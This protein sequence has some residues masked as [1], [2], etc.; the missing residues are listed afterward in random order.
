MRLS[1]LPLVMALAA[2]L[3][4]ALLPPTGAP[5][6][7]AA[8][9]TDSA[10][11]N[12]GSAVPCLTQADKFAVS[13]FADTIYHPAPA[14]DPA[15]AEAS[16][17]AKAALSSVGTNNNGGAGARVASGI[18]SVYGL[19]YDDGAVSGRPRLFIAAF[20]KRLSGFGHGGP[21]GVYVYDL[22]QRSGSDAARFI[23]PDAGWDRA[24]GVA[25]PTDR[26]AIAHVGRSGLGDMEISPDG[27][28]LFVVNI[29]AR[30]IERY[31][32]SGETPVRGTPIS[33]EGALDAIWAPL[34]N[35][36]GA[37]EAA[38]RADT[39][40]FALEFSPLD[41]AANPRLVL[42]LTDTNRRA[43][44]DGGLNP[45]TAYP[46]F[47]LASYALTS[48]V[49]S[50][51]LSQ[52]LDHPTIRNRM[53]D[54]QID[55][56]WAS[57][58]EPDSAHPYGARG[59]AGWNPWHDNLAQMPQI[60]VTGLNQAIIYPQ[61]LLADIEF[62][63]DGRR[64]Y[65]GL[66][67]RTGD[68]VFAA[69]PPPGEFSAVAQGDTLVYN[70]Q[71]AAW[72][73][74]TTARTSD[75][76]N[77]D[78][79]EQFVRPALS[80]FFDDNRHRFAANVSPFH[81]E[82]HGGA[83]ATTLQG[84]GKTIAERIVT[85]SLLGARQSGLTFYSQDGGAWASAPNV[86]VTASR[87]A[88]GKS[89]VLGDLEPLCTYAFV[90][91]KVWNDLDGEGDQDPGE[92]PIA[93]VTLEAFQ[94]SA[95]T[96]PP[97]ARAT[98]DASGSYRFA[99]PPNQ[100][101]RIRIGAADRTA[102]DG[103][104]SA[105]RFAP[106][107]RAAGND[108]RDSDASDVWGFVEFA[109]SRAAP[110]PGQTGMAIPAP[111]REQELTGVDIGLTRAPASGVIGDQVWVDL[112]RNGLQD[113][114]LAAGGQNLPE[115]GLAPNLLSAMSFTLIPDPETAVIGALPA[116]VRLPDGGYEFRKLPPGRYAVRFG[117]I[118]AGY[119]PT[120][121]Q[122]LGAPGDGSDS[123]AALPE[124]TTRYVTL[125]APFPEGPPVHVNPDLDLG[126]LSDQT[127]L[128]AML[129]A[130]PLVLPNQE[131]V[132]DVGVMNL[133]GTDD[134]SD[135]RLVQQLPPGVRVDREQT[136]GVPA[137][138]GGV[139][140]GLVLTW[141]IGRL[142]MSV[143]RWYRVYA[144]SPGGMQPAAPGRRLVS[145]ATVSSSAQE[146][147]LAN[148]RAEAS[149]LL[150]RPEL[151]IAKLGP[152]EVNIGD[153]FVYTLQLTNRGSADASGVTLEDPLPA[154]ITFIRWMGQPP[155][156][157]V[158]RTDLLTVRCDG[159]ALPAGA[160]VAIR[161]VA[162]AEPTAPSSVSN[163]ATIAYPLSWADDPADNQAA[164]PTRVL[165][166]NPGV[167]IAILIDRPDPAVP[168]AF[169][170]GLSGAIRVRY[171]NGLL[172][173]PPG[174][175][176]GPAQST[177]LTL[178][179][180]AGDYTLGAL[181]KSCARA[182]YRVTCALG[183]LAPGAAGTITIPIALPAHFA[184]DRLQAIATIATTSPEAPADQNDNTASTGVDVVRPNVFVDA[185]GPTAIIGRGS[186]F[187]YTFD[188]GNLYRPAP[189]LTGTAA[190][191]VLRATLPREVELVSAD[192]APTLID[193][194][195]LT[196][197]LGD[198][199]PRAAGRITL[200]V[201]TAIDAGAS[202]RLDAAI[203]TTSP[204]DNPAD[205]ADSVI[206]AVVQPPA[207]IPDAEGD[208]RLALGSELD[209]LR[210]D[211]SPTNGVHL[212]DGLRFSW[213]AGETV[214]LTPR[215]SRLAIPDEAELPYPYAYRARVV[216]WS[217]RAVTIDGRIYDP[218]GADGG[219]RTGCRPGAAPAA[220]PRLLEGCAYG[221]VDGATLEAIRRAA[222]LREEQL[223]DQAR[224]YW[225]RP[226]APP[227]P[228]AVYLYAGKELKHV[229]LAVQVEIELQ[230]V[231]AAPGEING[232][233]LPE[234][235]LPDPQRQLLAETFDVTLLVPR[236]VVGPGHP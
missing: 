110:R 115:P 23:V 142:Q 3:L 78:G 131:I 66:R 165:R 36:W 30:R 64:M 118:P 37:L 148:N 61:P 91:G 46:G 122:A 155:A 217:L 53:R 65:L 84:D 67:D 94:G 213:P 85:T 201:R 145:S 193:G 152:A 89:A 158:Y 177:T 156:G 96:A 171:G 168:G 76:V 203:S 117:N 126:L 159:L 7:A 105:F 9:V 29:T 83:L 95:A 81:V 229:R 55:G 50:P 224:L 170:V 198:L 207:T 119:T 212:T 101:I 214:E 47:H 146:A 73:L 221:Y 215:L 34:R 92:P 58:D 163:S 157:C 12:F 56:V 100:N 40:P 28:E 232:F 31:N 111:V 154:G 41:S 175:L 226:P 38:A 231:N 10:G 160:S 121:L 192:L 11:D 44:R 164:L 116:A 140:T 195:T 200:L 71:N 204:G 51:V 20:L 209:P 206:T 174:V 74:Q 48:G 16:L 181:P 194:R 42:G 236:S 227:L 113:G 230:I 162:R 176:R 153:E 166:P 123:D 234:V 178:D 228:A 127:D 2:L 190:G 185:D 6:P 60:P 21:G 93:G 219:G 57:T 182:G 202:L 223:R 205:N 136:T 216:G 25:D 98:T 138:S 108:T 24:S 103:I 196:W 128:L 88:G 27:R 35:K 172:A 135:V 80:D 184:P 173:P 32:I 75:P 144:R 49:W 137:I 86:L 120:A 199:A 208:L 72:V 132:Y 33:I 139:E 141:E 149:T 109:G 19:A 90:S 17:N 87:H 59:I 104:V 8:Q 5:L 43:V 14:G 186:V 63:H 54:S 1:H 147:N 102:P 114:Y 13:C 99:L 197:E 225:T 107:N 22:Q 180:S 68:M 130:T 218:A 77:A 69:E 210:H 179:L 70:L 106:P 129:E 161:F 188:Y 26:A 187:P 4:A 97:L 124:L 191:A 151:G 189:A 52:A 143:P 235:P 222:P 112:N 233:P 220:A 183:V 15:V 211:A 45:P 79:G 82:N 169:P 133:G 167:A 150:V 125:A 62:S 39:F 18:G 134:A